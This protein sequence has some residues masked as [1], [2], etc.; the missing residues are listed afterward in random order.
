M[1]RALG[2]LVFRKREGPGDEVKKQDEFGFAAR[3]A[4]NPIIFNMASLYSC[5]ANIVDK[6]I[7][8]QGTAKSL[9]IKS[10]FPRKKKL[11][12]LVCETLKCKF[13]VNSDGMQ[14]D[15]PPDL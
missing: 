2:L 13:V 1:D 14:T 12:A 11:Y 9:A 10:P 7:K 8:K 15:P 3:P 5:A 4:V 6:V